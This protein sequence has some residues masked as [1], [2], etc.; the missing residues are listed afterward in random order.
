MQTIS[1]WNKSKK[2]KGMT[3]DKETIWKGICLPE[4]KSHIIK[5][6][7]EV[8]VQS[9]GCVRLNIMQCGDEPY[10]GREEAGAAADNLLS[11]WKQNLNWGVVYLTFEQHNK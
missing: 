10:H 4:K 5:W 1:S 6:V 8:K 7:I 2:K 9:E 3:R 11:G